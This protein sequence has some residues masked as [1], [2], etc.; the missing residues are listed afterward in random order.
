MFCVNL[1]FLS[2]YK[3][4]QVLLSVSSSLLV[5]AYMLHTKPFSTVGNG[6]GLSGGSALLCEGINESIILMS[7]LLCFL[8]F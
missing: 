7:S 6:L 2:N 3:L 5:F 8:Y 1:V 4:F